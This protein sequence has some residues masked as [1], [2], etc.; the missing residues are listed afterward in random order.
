MLL[1]HPILHK[2]GY[3]TEGIGKHHLRNWFAQRETDVDLLG[4]VQWCESKE[5]RES[6][7]IPAMPTPYYGLDR[8]DFTGGNDNWT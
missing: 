1:W 2:P 3:A 5:M 7:R 4:E 8:V 6:G